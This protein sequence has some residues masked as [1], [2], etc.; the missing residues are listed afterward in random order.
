MCTKVALKPR[1]IHLISNFYICLIW[2]PK[3]CKYSVDKLHLWCS[4]PSYHEMTTNGGVM[5]GHRLRRW[6][7]IEPPSVYH[8]QYTEIVLYTFLI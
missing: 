5:L 2:R 6:A 8:L 3:I 7:N 1:S 4:N